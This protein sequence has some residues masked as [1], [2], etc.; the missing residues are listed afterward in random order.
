MVTHGC[1]QAPRI[2]PTQSHNRATTTAAGVP[3]SLGCPVMT[4]QLAGRSTVGHRLYPFYRWVPGGG[5][6]TR[7]LPQ[8]SRTPLTIKPRLRIPSGA[9]GT[10]QPQLFHVRRHPIHSRDGSSW[11]IRIGE[12]CIEGE[13]AK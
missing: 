10:G 4:V 9:N 8:P 2:Q 5:V 12:R 11:S 3:P 1:D 13:A 7:H 6:R